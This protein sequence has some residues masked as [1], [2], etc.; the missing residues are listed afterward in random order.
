MKKLSNYLEN[1]LKWHFFS[2]K[3]VPVV[4]FHKIDMLA[5]QIFRKNFNLKRL[6]KY[7]GVF[8]FDSLNNCF[9]N[10]VT[11]NLYDLNVESVN[12]ESNLFIMM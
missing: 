3:T 5:V 11:F 10:Q 6:I 8:S 1:D 9:N 2:T 4:H 7:G 12:Y